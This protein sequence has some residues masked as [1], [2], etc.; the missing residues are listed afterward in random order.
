MPGYGLVTDDDYY[1]L[2]GYNQ[3]VFAVE[4]TAGTMM[5][6]AEDGGEKTSLQTFAQE[7]EALDQEYPVNYNWEYE[8]MME[9]M[10]ANLESGFITKEESEEILA[11]LQQYPERVE[12]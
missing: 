12:E 9:N 8:E 11:K 2:V 4:E 7:I 3:G 10:K 1:W 6:V 5:A